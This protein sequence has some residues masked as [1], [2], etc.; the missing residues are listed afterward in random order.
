MDSINKIIC[1]YITVNWLAPWLKEGKSQVA[2][3]NK[4]NV[5]ESTVRKL[6]GEKE[7][8]I[9]V[10]T[11][12]RICKERNINLSEFFKELEEKHPPIR[13]NKSKK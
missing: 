12:Y 6:K 13:V 10:E 1:K 9:P 11:L 2:F 8:R 7:Y 5:E 4:H 3:G